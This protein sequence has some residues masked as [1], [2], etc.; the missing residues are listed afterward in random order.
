VRFPIPWNHGIEKE[1]LNLEELEHVPI[2]NSAE[3]LGFKYRVAYMPRSA[4]RSTLGFMSELWSAA[5]ALS[6]RCGYRVLLALESN[7]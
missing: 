2:N 5:S 1:M 6:T 3:L 7:G 4:L